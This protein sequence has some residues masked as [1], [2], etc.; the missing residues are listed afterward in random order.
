[1][2]CCSRRS[3]RSL[4]PL[5]LVAAMLVGCGG[6]DATDEDGT[7]EPAA[8][9]C[10][11]LPEDLSCR[12]FGAPPSGSWRLVAYCPTVDGYAPLGDTCPPARFGVSGTA[13]GLLSF[14]DATRYRFDYRAR[15]LTIT[16]RI[17]LDCY[18]GGAGFCQGAI[19]GG[20]CGVDDEACACEQQVVE[21]DTAEIGTWSLAGDRLTMQTTSGPRFEQEFCLDQ[22]ARYLLLRRGGTA[23][24][25]GALMLFVAD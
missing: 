6:G 17:P 4:A 25:T 23:D 22:D 11:A 24:I 7:T 16:S 8:Y 15:D 19:L 12:A 10:T 13:E 2:S 5:G 14:V 9:S 20:S 1:M 18:G 21:R 3:V